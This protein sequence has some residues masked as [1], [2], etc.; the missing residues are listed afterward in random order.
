MLYGTLQMFATQPSERR[1][2]NHLYR[3]CLSGLSFCE[4]FMARTRSG[5]I[6]TYFQLLV[7][8]RS[9]AL[10]INQDTAYT[11]IDA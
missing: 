2:T 9:R 7:C 4:A 3:F 8:T 11:S 1:V 5:T 10:Y 6:T